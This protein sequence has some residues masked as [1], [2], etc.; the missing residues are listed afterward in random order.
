MVLTV[1]AACWVSV[2]ECLIFRR[3]RCCFARTDVRRRRICVLVVWR[4]VFRVF[5]PDSV[6]RDAD[7]FSL[8]LLSASDG[9]WIRRNFLIFTLTR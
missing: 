7:L 5:V 4:C 2:A 8:I 6:Q 3:L 9:D 1:V